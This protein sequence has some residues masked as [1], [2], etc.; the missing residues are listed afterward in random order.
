MRRDGMKRV[1][2][3]LGPMRSLGEICPP[4]RSFADWRRFLEEARQAGVAGLENQDPPVFATPLGYSLLRRWRW[5]EES[6]RR[7]LTYEAAEAWWKAT[8]DREN[9]A[10]EESMRSQD[11]TRARAMAERESFR[12]PS[13]ESVRGEMHAFADEVGL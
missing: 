12:K 3:L 9:D 8:A 13:Q 11:R 1:S 2:E 4:A 6:E 5:L 10:L 7:G